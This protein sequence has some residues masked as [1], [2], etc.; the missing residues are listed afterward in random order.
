MSSSGPY[1]HH[2]ESDR[3]SRSEPDLLSAL[4]LGDERAFEQFVRDQSPRLLAVIRRIL[5]ND[6]DA[7]EARQDAFVSVFRA[8]AR[9]EG[10]AGLST[11][12]HRIAMNAALMKLRGKKR[13]P[14]IALEDVLPRFDGDGHANEPVEP[15]ENNAIELSA[16]SEM[17]AIIRELID[18]LP[19]NYR[20]ALLLR[21]LE[22]VPSD[23][24]AR[25]L[26]I[27]RNS[28][29][30]RVHRARQA[31]RA[32]LDRRLALHSRSERSCRATLPDLP[33]DRRF[34]R[35]VLRCDARPPAAPR[36]RAAPRR[37]PALHPL[38]QELQDDGCADEARE[39]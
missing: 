31:L 26:E 27:T 10:S 2:N 32:L 21:D 13:R 15:W 33:A 24:V 8:I 22:E 14:E 29:K 3:G 12:L 1:S 38:P 20:V 39:G 34:H 7:N 9:F 25:M 19:E 28:V 4:R 30:I 6:E 37:L 5:R 16:Q 17:R 23:E 18:Q 11:W 36:V 35:R